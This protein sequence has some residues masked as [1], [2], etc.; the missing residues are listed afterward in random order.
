MAS[1][2]CLGLSERRGERGGRETTRMKKE[3]Q[4]EVRRR[5]GRG[6]E[7]SQARMFTKS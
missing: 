2:G 6:G 7:R 3:N 1:C 5:K 4:R